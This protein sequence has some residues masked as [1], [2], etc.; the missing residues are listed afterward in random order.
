MTLTLKFYTSVAKELK[1]KF[2]KFWG[3][4]PTFVEVTGEKLVKGTFLPLILNRVGGLNL[5]GFDFRFN[6]IYDKIY[7]KIK[8]TMILQYL[9]SPEEGKIRELTGK[10]IAEVHVGLIIKSLV[11]LSVIISSFL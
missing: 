5:I 4:I 8:Y 11:S 9:S 2:R 1:L 7:D 6:E 3:L 10:E